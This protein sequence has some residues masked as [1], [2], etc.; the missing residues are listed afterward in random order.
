LLD[1]IWAGFVRD[2]ARL[3]GVVEGYDELGDVFLFEMVISIK[4][5]AVSE[6]FF[7]V[8]AHQE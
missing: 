8:L 4:T 2:A 5:N 1:N 6:E 7:I 3:G